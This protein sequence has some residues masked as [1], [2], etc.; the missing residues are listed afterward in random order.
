MRSVHLSTPIAIVKQPV[1]ICLLSLFLMLSSCKRTDKNFSLDY[2]DNITSIELS[3]DSLATNLVKTNDGWTVNDS[4]K[5]GEEQLDML[6]YIINTQ[7]ITSEI[8][9]G[10]YA[11]ASDILV[12]DGIRI[13]VFDKKKIVLDITVAASDS[14]GYFGR[15]ENNK[16]LYR[17]SLPD[18]IDNPFD[19]LSAAPSYWKHNVIV[20]VLPS[21]IAEVA[22]E[23]MEDPEKS[24]Q[25]N[26]HEDGSLSLLDIYHNQEVA[27]ISYE[28]LNTYLSYFT[29]LSYEQLLDLEPNEQKAIMLSDS[30]YRI[31]ITTKDGQR[32]NLQLFYITDNENLDPYGNALK[33]NPNQFYLSLNDGRDIA[34]AKWVNFDLLLRDLTYFVEN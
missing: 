2:I 22:I 14:L 5:A 13:K 18:I 33:Y 25:I 29:G 1:F 9:Q 28:K 7:Y 23:N 30:P 27:N 17:L 12:K 11:Y 19:F 26:R 21:E 16:Q 32:M 20:S 31:L 10:Q 15:S 4:Y 8:L 6:L 24:F 34:L 3:Q